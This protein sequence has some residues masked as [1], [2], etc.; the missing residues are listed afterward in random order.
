MHQ[1][2]RQG[3]RGACSFSPFWFL[4]V[5]FAPDAAQHGHV[6]Q[7]CHVTQSVSSGGVVHLEEL[8][9][10]SFKK[11]AVEE[12]DV[13]VS[14]VLQQLPKVGAVGSRE[15]GTS[16]VTRHTSHLT[17]HTS[18]VAG[19]AAARETVRPSRRQNRQNLA[20]AASRPAAAGHVTNVVRH[21]AANC[22]TFVVTMSCVTQ[23]QIV[24]LLTCCR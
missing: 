5:D 22:N 11:N 20:A 15:C 14:H 13:S 4:A 8:L 24:T 19:A 16:H 10:Q 2:H 23:R 21:T 18:H 3:A 6:T 12:G 1:V 17:P 7:S 9:A